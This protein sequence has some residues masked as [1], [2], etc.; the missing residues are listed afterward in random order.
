MRR[1]LA[2]VAVGVAV[3]LGLSG[4]TPQIFQHPYL[5]C[6]T[7]SVDCHLPVIQPGH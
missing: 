6:Y 1:K 2:A 5:F 4:C 7:L 3:L